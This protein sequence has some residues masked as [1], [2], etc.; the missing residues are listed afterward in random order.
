MAKH[1]LGVM[2]R[3]VYLGADLSPAINAPST[4]DFIDKNGQVL[5]DAAPLHRG[6]WAGARGGLDLASGPAQAA[7]MNFG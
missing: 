4:N 1:R 5:R 3:N 7:T 6:V 2:T